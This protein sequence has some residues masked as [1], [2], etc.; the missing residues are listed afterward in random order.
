MFSV[1]KRYNLGS[2][3]KSVCTEGGRA[4]VSSN[5]WC[6]DMWC[7]MWQPG[8]NPGECWAFSGSEGYLVVQLSSA[9]V[10]TEVSI[11][12]IP[13]SL[14]P[15]GDIKSAP[16]EF[17]VWVSHRCVLFRGHPDRPHYRSWLS[18]FPSDPYGLQTWKR[19]GVEKTKLLSILSR[20]SQLCPGNW[21]ANLTFLLAC[22]IVQDRMIYQNEIWT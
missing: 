3:I 15:S 6:S 11:E 13:V 17:T 10:V 18:V 5:C 4:E 8:V 21:C 1:N 16:R 9:V 22:N 7:V 20:Q 12:H 14:A 19:N 2:S